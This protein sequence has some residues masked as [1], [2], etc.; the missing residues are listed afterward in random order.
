MSY[1]KDKRLITKILNKFNMYVGM[2]E[3]YLNN[4][5]VIVLYLRLNL[6]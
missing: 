2:L 1:Y 4:T 5:I 3:K 6:I